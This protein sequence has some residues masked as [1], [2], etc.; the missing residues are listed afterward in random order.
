M[1]KVIKE[2]KTAKFSFVDAVFVE[3][4]EYQKAA[5]ILTAAGYKHKF[6][7]CYLKQDGG[8]FESWNIGEDGTLS[9]KS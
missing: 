6:K 5:D 2:C 1:I 9:D 4:E 8:R 3:P 7:K